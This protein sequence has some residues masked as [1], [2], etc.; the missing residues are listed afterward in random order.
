MIVD[1][2]ESGYSPRAASIIAARP[3][4]GRGSVAVCPSHSEHPSQCLIFSG[5][6]DP[7]KRGRVP[8]A[9][10]KRAGFSDRAR[11]SDEEAVAQKKIQS[12]LSP[13]R[14]TDGQSARSSALWESCARCP[15]RRARCFTVR[16][17]D[18][19]V[20]TDLMEQAFVKLLQ[21]LHPAPLRAPA[22]GRHAPERLSLPPT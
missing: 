22:A 5:R 2:H 21:I 19:R 13:A 12:T 11:Q 16:D 1:C 9:H 20:M 7:M 14:T 10:R 18:P 8:W 17:L 3:R 4:A 6:G 15:F